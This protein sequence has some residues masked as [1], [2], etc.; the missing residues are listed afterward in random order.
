MIWR[1]NSLV[2]WSVNT[3]ASVKWIPGE[4]LAPGEM[5]PSLF[6]Y[7]QREVCLTPLRPGTTKLTREEHAN[8]LF[9]FPLP[10]ICLNDSALQE[11]LAV[12]FSCRLVSENL[13]GSRNINHSPLS[14]PMNLLYNH[15][16]VRE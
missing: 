12:I 6:S 11:I 2:E 1:Y 5:T 4:I 9:S 14:I 15:G 10:I 3:M 7:W 16:G 8:H 13:L